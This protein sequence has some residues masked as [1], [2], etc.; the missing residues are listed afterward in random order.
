M[1][2]NDLLDKSWSEQVSTLLHPGIHDT[3]PYVR[4]FCRKE[5]PPC[6]LLVYVHRLSPTHTFAHSFTKS[7]K[8]VLEMLPARDA[9][10]ATTIDW[11]SSD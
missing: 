10:A 8:H 2:L 11:P 1:T 6:P 3:I 7:V 5:A 4:Q 9:T